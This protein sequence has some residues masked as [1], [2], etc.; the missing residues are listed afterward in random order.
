MISSAFGTALPDEFTTLPLILEVVSALTESENKIE[1][2]RTL[3][4]WNLNIVTSYER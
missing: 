2:A 4:R 3:K 1:N